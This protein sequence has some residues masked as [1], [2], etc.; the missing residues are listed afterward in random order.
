MSVWYL[1]PYALTQVELQILF[2]IFLQFSRFL[3]VLIL[4]KHQCTPNYINYVTQFR[5][6]VANLN[7]GDKSCKGVPDPLRFGQVDEHHDGGVRE[8]VSAKRSFY[9]ICV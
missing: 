4:K 8:L 2:V 9:Q 1:H 6:K 5:F 3:L 7:T